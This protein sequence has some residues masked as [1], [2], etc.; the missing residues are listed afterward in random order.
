[1][2]YFGFSPLPLD[3]AHAC[4]DYHEKLCSCDD[5]VLAG[6]ASLMAPT[7]TDQVPPLSNEEVYR[8]PKLNMEQVAKL[9]EELVKF[10]LSLPGHGRT[11]VGS[12]SLSSGV[13]IKLIHEVAENAHTFSS[14]EDIEKRLPFFSQSHAISIWKI[15]EQFLQKRDQDAISPHL[16]CIMHVRKKEQNIYEVKYCFSASEYYTRLK[17]RRE[18]SHFET[19][20]EGPSSHE[21]I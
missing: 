4:C 18:N 19:R 8:Y 1:M 3:T 9:N 2:E 5:C 21:L 7:L 17:N 15:V 13:T 16:A 14:A 11:I 6:V 20:L 10:R 12:S